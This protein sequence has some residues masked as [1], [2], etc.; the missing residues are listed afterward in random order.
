ML[1]M[2][3]IFREHCPFCYPLSL[4][5][6]RPICVV[7]IGTASFSPGFQST[8]AVRSPRRRYVGLDIPIT[9]PCPTWGRTTIAEFDPMIPY[10]VV[11]QEWTQTELLKQIKVQRPKKSSR[12]TQTRP[13]AVLVSLISDDCISRRT[14]LPRSSNYLEMVQSS[15]RAALAYILAPR[16]NM[17]LSVQE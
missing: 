16:C 17:R 15:E 12:V 7:E 14:A 11:L 4:S 5:P 13:S 10:R 8:V 3:I 2:S 1:C 9:S 6:F